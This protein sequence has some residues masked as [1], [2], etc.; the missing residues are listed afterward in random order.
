MS[1]ESK[2]E[3]ELQ[4]ILIGR[5]EKIVGRALST[6]ADYQYM[7]DCIATRIGEY[8]SPTTIK[9]IN[10]YL[11]EPVKARRSTL[12]ILSRVVGYEGYD[13]FCANAMVSEC[14]SDPA[15]GNWLDVSELT[16]GDRVELTWFP[17]RR[18]L[19][20]FLGEDLWEV[21]DS[22]ATR[23]RAGQRFRC[24]HI[25]AGEPLQI[26]LEPSALTPRMVGYV[27]GRQHG[28]RFR[29]I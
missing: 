29:R 27:C 3:Q 14:D 10:G 12:N 23:L 6:S 16:R 11:S 4:R 28:V 21:V 9:R 7:S 17:D 25:I 18:C 5:L 8:I 15:R 20:C 13:D 24:R 26:L 22:E 1:T 19:I 2:S